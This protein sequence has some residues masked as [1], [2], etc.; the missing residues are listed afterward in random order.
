MQQKWEQSASVRCKP[1]IVFDK[2]DKGYWFPLAKQ[3]LSLHPDVRELGDE[4][5]TYLLTQSL[6][7]Y[8]NEI[9]IIETK[10]ISQV[11]I[12]AITDT[13]GIVFNSEQKLD[14][15]TIMVDEAYHA[16]VAYDAMLQIQKY[17]GIEPLPLPGSIEI[18]YAIN[19]AIDKLPSQYHETFKFIAICLAENTLTKEIVSMLGQ[20]ETHPFFQRMINDHFSDETRH[21]GL[22][23]KLLQQIWVSIDDDCKNNIAHVLPGFINSY[24]SV[25]IQINFEK[26]ILV[27]MGFKKEHAD[28]ILVDTY[29]DHFQITAHHPM[30]KNI[31][32]VMRKAGVLDKFVSAQCQKMGWL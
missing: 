5:L 17:T 22:F 30:L 16:Y 32:D 21:S 11:I 23:F 27:S 25:T 28:Q 19:E 20:N 18:E 8:S 31:L 9:S 1:R 3:L 4:A 6:Y 13:S 26:T 7:R 14:L 12:S 29:G 2:E 24:L 10:I 15:Y